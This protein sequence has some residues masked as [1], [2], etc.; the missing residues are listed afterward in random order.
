MSLRARF[1]AEV[2]TGPSSRAQQEV[3]FG[4]SMVY[5]CVRMC[6]EVCGGVCLCACL[7]GRQVNTRHL[8][9]S[10]STLCFLRWGLSLELESSSSFG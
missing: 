7:C 4:M 10:L 9:L 6:V 2:T 8:L 1:A 5:V 3:I